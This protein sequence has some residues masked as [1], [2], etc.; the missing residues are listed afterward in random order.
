MAGFFKV[1]A[2]EW[3]REH[4][5]A[6]WSADQPATRAEAWADYAWQL[7]QLAFRGRRSGSATE[8]ASHWGWKRARA[9]ELMVEV[10]DQLAAWDTRETASE[11][12]SDQ[13]KGKVANAGARVKLANSNRTRTSPEWAENVPRTTDECLARAR[14][15]RTTATST[16]P[17]SRDG[18]PRR[19]DIM[20]MWRDEH[21]KRFGREY[22][23]GARDRGRAATWLEHAA[24]D[25]KA[26]AAG[27]ERLRVAMRVYMLAVAS[28]TAWPEGE[29]AQTKWF[30][31][32]VAKWLQSPPD[33]PEW[34]TPQ[35]HPRR[36]SGV[37]PTQNLIDA[38]RRL[39]E[40][41]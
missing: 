37:S 18:G 10:R 26:P 28:G 15:D 3:E 32:D 29:P 9:Y 1:L 21:R 27:L 16:A 39:E 36:K 20:E 31:T 4:Y 41:C 22:P 33:A 6:R 8:N 38:Q 23:W 25:S 2:P 19:E 24:V 40:K 11:P 7:D 14:S 5:S 35:A 34:V 12:Q 30:D 17:A 13:G